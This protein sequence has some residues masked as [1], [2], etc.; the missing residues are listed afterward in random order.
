[1]RVIRK[2]TQRNIRLALIICTYHRRKSLRANLK[3]ITDSRFF[4]EGDELL[5]KLDIYVVDNASELELKDIAEADKAKNGQIR[6]FHN[7][8]SGGSGGFGRG[9]RE[10]RKFAG[11]GTGYSDVILMDDDAFVL[12]ESL[13]RLYAMLFYRRTEYDTA[14]IAGRMFCLNRR[15]VQYTAAEIWNAGD[16]RHVGFMKDMTDIENL[17]AVNEPVLH[18]DDISKKDTMVTVGKK[19]EY[20][21]WWFACFPYEFVKNNDPLPFFL[22]C[23]DVEYGLRHGGTPI[24][25]NGIQVWHETAAN[26]DSAILRYYDRRNFRIVNDL[27]HLNAKNEEVIDSWIADIGNAHSAGDWKEEYLRISAFRDYLLWKLKGFPKDIERSH[28]RLTRS[29]SRRRYRILNA[30]RWRMVRALAHRV[31]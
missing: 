17:N 3:R 20:S 12:P 22:H 23:D 19:A 14:V 30:V 18:D 6:L 16:L 28:I 11:E 7:N 1:M 9:I 15:E 31:L 29:L 27:Y 21:G 13:Y 4:D 8:N 2:Q 26:R 5:G 10:V 25:L 24:I